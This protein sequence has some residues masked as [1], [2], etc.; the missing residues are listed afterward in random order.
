VREFSLSLTGRKAI[1]TG[2][3]IPDDGTVVA[4]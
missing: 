4:M 2:A 1:V 3:V